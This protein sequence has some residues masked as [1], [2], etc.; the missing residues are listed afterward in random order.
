M[1]HSLQYSICIIAVSLFCIVTL[2]FVLSLGQAI[3]PLFG[4]FASS[5]EASYRSASAY[6]TS[7]IAGIILYTVKES[8]T[9][10]IIALLAG[11]PAAYF[12]SHKKLWICRILSSLSAVPLC[13]PPLIIALGYIATFGMAGYINKM[14][15]AAFN[16]P[17]PPFTF[18]YSFWGIVIT[19]G[20]Y[21]FPLIMKT[22]ADSWECLD[23]SQA[24][25]AKILGASRWR[26][27][28]TITVFQLLP[29]IVSAS[30]PVFIYSFFSFMI[31]MMFGTIGGTTLETAIFHAGRSIL[32]FHSAAILACIETS[33]AL[34]ILTAYALL[35]Q[36]TIRRHGLSLSV[37][38]NSKTRLNKKEIF[39]AI[40][41]FA[42]IAIFFILPL[43][44]I[45][46][47]SVS[48]TGTRQASFT[49]S[50]WKKILSLKSFYNA[51]KNTCL[52]SICSASLSTAAGF[53]YAVFLRLN[54]QDTRRSI[55]NSI[56][57]TLPL[58]PMT[59]SSVVMGIGMTLLVHRGTPVH[60]VLAQ[61]AIAFPFA[62]R[63]LYA[64]LNAIPQTTIDAARLLSR[65]NTDLIFSVLIPY[66]KKNIISALGF[67]F[68]ISAGDATLPLVLAIHKFDTLS[69]Y[70][71]RLAGSYRFGEACVCGLLLGVLCMT[72]FSVSKK[73]ILP[74]KR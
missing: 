7:A 13:I 24:E 40:I 39:P 35:E 14:L 65:H 1:K 17:E 32:N 26:I 66:C 74:G 34:L 38:K 55:R 41:F 50:R 61:S 18:L 2:A 62:F 5:A 46:V 42:V 49:L 23:V 28:R 31:V 59:V 12:L 6:T 67:C 19:Q 36:K 3:S 47:G 22:V 44:S 48:T 45:A 56:L 9:S 53:V 51:L 73:N 16:L 54:V 64:P 60:L 68:A 63:Q 20:F 30:I 70:T 33:S 10:V 52:T 58:L 43:L 21:N 57:T 37:E 4:S 71:Y 27:F 15:M 25:A 69:L 72:V 8:F 11:I 29:S